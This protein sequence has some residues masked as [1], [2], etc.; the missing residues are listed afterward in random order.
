MSEQNAEYVSVSGVWI[1]R[2]GDNVECLVELP[3]GWVVVI[4]EQL[5]GYFSHII[6]PS[7]IRRCVADELTREGAQIDSYGAEK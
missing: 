2:I 6:E 7:G 3:S 1:R 4:T 5:D